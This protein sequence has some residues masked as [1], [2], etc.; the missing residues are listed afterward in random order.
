[1]LLEWFLT[2]RMAVTTPR[3]SIFTPSL[4]KISAFFLMVPNVCFLIS[5]KWKKIS[6]NGY[7]YCEL[8]PWENLILEYERNRTNLRYWKIVANEK[9]IAEIGEVSSVRNLVWAN[10]ATK[11]TQNRLKRKIMGRTNVPEKMNWLYSVILEN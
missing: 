4:L 2:T 6:I 3:I 1:M 8:H 10:H 5:R 9:C 11:K 7:H